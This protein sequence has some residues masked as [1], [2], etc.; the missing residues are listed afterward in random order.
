MAN[1]IEN[2][3]ANRTIA[4]LNVLAKTCKNYKLMLKQDLKKKRKT[5]ITRKI[6]RTERNANGSDRT[7]LS[8]GMLG[9]SIASVM[10]FNMMKTRTT[11]SKDFHASKRQHSCLN[12]HSQY[13]LAIFLYINYS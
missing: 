3:I 7:M 13:P 8:S 11:L 5:S 9:L 4:V 12:L 6:F 1:E 10:Q 2:K